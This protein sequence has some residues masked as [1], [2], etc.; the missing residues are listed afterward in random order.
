[1]KKKKK[2]ENEPEMHEVVP[3]KQGIQIL[4]TEEDKTGSDIMAMSDFFS[5]ALQEM[6][7]ELVSTNGLVTVSDFPLADFGV[8]NE[9]IRTIGVF[10]APEFDLLPDFDALPKDI[11]EKYRSGELVLGESK[12]VDGNIRAVL[13]DSETKERVKDVTLKKVER[14]DVTNDIV[15]N[16]LTQMQ[17]RQISDKLDYMA[18]EQ[19]YLIDFTRN[20]AI[21]RPFLDARDDILSAQLQTDHEEQMKYL[22]SAS[23]KLQ[24]AING[25]YVDMNTI[26]GHLAE[27]TKKKWF[28][29]LNR[30]N[31]D[32]QISRFTKDLQVVTKYV[33]VQ[34]QVYHYLGDTERAKGVIG[35]YQGAINRLFAKGVVD[36]DKSV[37]LLI[38]ENVE[39][40]ENNLDCWYNMEKELKPAIEKAYEQIGSKD[41]YIITTEGEDNE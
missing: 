12:Q 38:H 4:V 21:I 24:S 2:K 22:R 36:V 5:V 14:T 16:M 13:I 27:E 19:S 7:K 29:R 31:I 28:L 41:V 40:G 37:A 34:V 9:A 3:S 1:M 17:L 15:Q 23:E 20:Q 11:K 33:G 25:V 39:Y 26:E 10:R 32:K 18:S 8:L 6:S 30:S 35:T